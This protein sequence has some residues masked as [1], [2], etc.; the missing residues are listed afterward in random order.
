MCV[1]PYLQ[2]IARRSQPPYLDLIDDRNVKC[3][4]GIL[5]K[6]VVWWTV[7]SR[8]KNGRCPN[9]RHEEI[10]LPLVSGR[11][12]VSRTAGRRVHSSN[13]PV[14][15][16][17]DSS[18]C[19][20]N[21]N[22]Q[23]WFDLVFH[24]RSLRLWWIVG[25]LLVNCDNEMLE[26][27]L[28]DMSSTNYNGRMND[29]I[30]LPAKVFEWIFNAGQLQ[31]TSVINDCNLQADDWNK[32]LV[33]G[34]L[35]VAD[36]CRRR[37][38]NANLPKSRCRFRPKVSNW[39]LARC[40]TWC[41]VT[42][43]PTW[44]RVG[45]P[46]MTSSPSLC[47]SITPSPSVRCTCTPTAATRSTRLIRWGNTFKPWSTCPTIRKRSASWNDVSTPTDSIQPCRRRRRRRRRWGATPRKP[48][49]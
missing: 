16:T 48:I 7:G 29:V 15:I 5:I 30:H 37:K 14:M 41:P 31:T 44:V 26:D 2:F 39:W 49:S 18:N 13:R 47:F 34:C 46:T 1:T 43:W 38:K 35:L 22:V 40:A 19:I 8:Q 4:D 21:C 24:A 17:D 36:T 6:F 20:F 10:V 25:T 42:R 33:F 32:R 23:P 3:I 11:S 9:E 12:R 27:G 45:P 28:A